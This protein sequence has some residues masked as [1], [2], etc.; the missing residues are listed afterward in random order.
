MLAPPS[1]SVVLCAAYGHAVALVAIG[2]SVSVVDPANGV[3]TEVSIANFLATYD[4]V[5]I[6][7]IPVLEIP[8]VEAEY[9]GVWRGPVAGPGGPRFVR[10]GRVKRL[11]PT[12]PISS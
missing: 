3:R 2:E 12:R 6:V 9:D 1:D 7:N 4:Y 10:H 8:H 5:R 11:A